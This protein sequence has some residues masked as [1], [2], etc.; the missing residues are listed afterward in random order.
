MATESE[1]I[2]GIMEGAENIHR[3]LLLLRDGETVR[4][5][6]QLTIIDLLIEGHTKCLEFGTK[7]LIKVLNNGQEKS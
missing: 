5:Q 6:E 3:N 2:K 1:C 7:A 4:T